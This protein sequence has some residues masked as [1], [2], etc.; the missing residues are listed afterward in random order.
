MNDA[1]TSGSEQAYRAAQLAVFQRHCD[2]F[3]RHDLDAVVSIYTANVHYEEKTLRWDLHSRD[4]LRDQFGM[5]FAATSAMTSHRLDS[6]HAP[7][8]AAFLWR[9]TGTLH[10]GQR[11]DFPGTSLLTFTG[12][13]QVSH[14]FAMWNLA[15]LPERA[16]KDMGLD[17]AAAYSPYVAWAADGR[18]TA[19]ARLMDSYR[20]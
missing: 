20:A 6:I 4:E 12:D 11:V 5:I 7:D 16:A 1:R 2:G 8:R 19:A 14:D 10:S 18:G 3:A 17:L 9:F 15:E 13:G